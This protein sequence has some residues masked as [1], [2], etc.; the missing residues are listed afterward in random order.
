M[1]KEFGGAVNVILLLLLVIS[2]LVIAYGRLQAPVGDVEAV[3]A[4]A[5]SNLEARRI[6]KDFLVAHPAPDNAELSTL[7]RK[8]NEQITLSLSRTVTG[9]SALKS[10]A[11]QAK[12]DAIAQA[13]LARQERQRLA[14]KSFAEMSQQELATAVTFKIEDNIN[15]LL[16]MVCVLVMGSIALSGLRNVRQMEK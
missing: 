8:V 9:D 16:G 7:K 3:V 2:I 10:T 14:G 12:E 6:V 5:E 13:N 15:W 1:R 11:E 4:L